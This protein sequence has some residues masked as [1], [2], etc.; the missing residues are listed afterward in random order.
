[1]STPRTFA[2]HTPEELAKA[3]GLSA[4]DA[5][6]WKVPHDLSKRLRRIVQQKNLT[7]AELARRAMTSRSRVTAVLNDNLGHVSTDLLIRMLAA[8]GY[9][10]KVTV[11]RR[12]A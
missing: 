8:L 5:Q 9:R 1:M 12:A 6:E 2:A 4:A 7:H 10:V 11:T 3:L